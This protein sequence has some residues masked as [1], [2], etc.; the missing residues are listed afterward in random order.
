MEI[1]NMNI[2]NLFFVIVFLGFSSTAQATEIEIPDDKTV[3]QFETKIGTVTFLHQMHA[4]LSIAECTTCH[5]KIQ[6]EDTTVQAC[7]ECHKKDSQE[8]PKAKTA[9]H[10]RCTGCHQYTIDGGD[11]AGPVRKKC[12]LC[13]VKTATE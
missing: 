3:I 5:H 10:T 1:D 8:P 2:K 4:G 11:N 7:H 6:P 9:F 13:H 12:K